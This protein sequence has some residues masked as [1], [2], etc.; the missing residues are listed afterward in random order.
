MRATSSLQY[1]TRRQLPCRQ[2]CCRLVSPLRSLY[3]AANHLLLGVLQ[4]SRAITLALP[5][6]QLPCRQ[7]CCRLVETPNLPIELTEAL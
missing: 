7:G 1:L 5:C 4:A 3:S 2:G 6:R